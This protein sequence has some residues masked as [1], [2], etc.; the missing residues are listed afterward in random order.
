MK[1]R[2]R[3]KMLSDF[4]SNE[5]GASAIEYALIASLISIVIIGGATVLGTTLQAT[6]NSFAAFLG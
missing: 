3:V 5:S 4:L 2:K 1:D 6:F